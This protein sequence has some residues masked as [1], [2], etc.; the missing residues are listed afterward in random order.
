MA[1]A[2]QAYGSDSS[3]VTDTTPRRAAQKF[4]E[5]FPGKRKCN[6]T[7]GETDGKFF[8]VTYG[9]KG[10]WPQSWKDVTKTLAA[11]LPDEA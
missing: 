11:N 5:T 3:R 2:F 1:K 9:A 7:E 10:R 8:T 6:I 4:F